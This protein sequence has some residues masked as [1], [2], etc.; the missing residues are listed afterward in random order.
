[1]GLVAM[2]GLA[3]LAAW[4]EFVAST[5]GDTNNGFVEVD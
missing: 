5:H 4:T 2:H 3:V 1:M